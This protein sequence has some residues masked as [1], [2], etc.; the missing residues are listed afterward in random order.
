MPRFNIYLFE[1]FF[2]YKQNSVLPSIEVQNGTF[3]YRYPCSTE[4]SLNA[5]PTNDFLN[6]FTFPA[7]GRTLHPSLLNAVLSLCELNKSFYY[8]ISLS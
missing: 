6:S 2:R 3:K 4:S 8:Y 1:H 5:S 7:D